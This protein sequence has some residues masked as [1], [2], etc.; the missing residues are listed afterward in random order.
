M[1]NTVIAIAAS[2][3]IT[4]RISLSEPPE[5]RVVNPS[6]AQAL[7]VILLI[8]LIKPPVGRTKK[9]PPKTPNVNIMAVPMLLT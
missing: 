5:A 6:M 7:G 1:V 8:T 4:Y 3:R 9:L 2:A